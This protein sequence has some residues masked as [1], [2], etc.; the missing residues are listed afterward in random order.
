M[1]IETTIKNLVAQK[2]TFTF[3]I[4]NLMAYSIWIACAL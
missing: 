1:V 3:Y 4:Q 2:R